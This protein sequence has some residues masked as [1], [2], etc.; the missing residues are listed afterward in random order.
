M[1]KILSILTTLAAL[2]SA[3]ATASTD[4][5]H[6]KGGSVTSFYSIEDPGGCVRTDVTLNAWESLT[7]TGPGPFEPAPNLMLDIEQVDWCGLG[8]LRSAFGTSADFEISVSNS[9]TT[10]SVR[11]RVDLYDSVRGTTS[12]AEIDL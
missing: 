7:K 8:Y 1:R 6:H 4:F 9:T 2:L 10:A 12:S 11:G 3:P 5:Y